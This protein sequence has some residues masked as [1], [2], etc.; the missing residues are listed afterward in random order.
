MSPVT[1]IDGRPVAHA[2]PPRQRLGEKTTRVWGA[3]A[4]AGRTGATFGQLVERLQGQVD[5]WPVRDALRSLDRGGY[6]QYQG[7]KRWGRWVAT[8]RVP[9]DQT[10]P[11]WLDETPDA[12]DTAPLAPAPAPAPRTA[13]FS[14]FTEA[15]HEQ[16]VEPRARGRGRP[17]KEDERPEPAAAAP[18]AATPFAQAARVATAVSTA[19]ARDGVF[20]LHSTG[21]LHIVFGSEY[22]RM[23]PPVTRRFF[24]W[25]DRLGGT[26]L[27]RISDGAQA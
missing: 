9:A 7:D 24:A 18:A 14:V 17:R 8:D 25:L 23:P 16:L 15:Q 12:E 19:E 20:A 1:D 3:V 6:V 21:E 11:A 10:R 13:P 27:S 22:V 4:A 26:Q 2:H 5:H